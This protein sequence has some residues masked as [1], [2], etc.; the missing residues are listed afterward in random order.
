MFRVISFQ[1]DV[2]GVPCSAVDLGRCGL[3][4]EGASRENSS[5]E[6]G[7]TEGAPQK[8]PVFVAPPR[9]IA[10]ITAFLDQE[11]PDPAKRAKTE[12]DAE[13]EPPAGASRATSQGF[14]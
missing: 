1:V 5:A 8:P 14:L 13:A 6:S 10:D 4:P 9:T 7:P 2:A 3:G 12:A 11:K